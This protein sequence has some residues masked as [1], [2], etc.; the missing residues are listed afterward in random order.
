MMRWI[1]GSSLKLRLLVVALAAALM[2]FGVRQLQDASVDALPEFAPVTVEVQTEALGLSAVEV[3]ELITVPIEQNL[4]NGVA[5]LDEIQSESLVGLSRIVMR[6]E[7]GTDPLRARQVVQERLTQWRD[8]PRVSKPPVMIQPL[9]ATSRVMIVR[10]SSTELSPIDMSVLARWTIKP[11]LMG[12]PGVANVSIWGQRERQLQVLVDPARLRERG[13]TLDQVIETTGNALWVSPLSFLEASVPG[14][15]GFIDTPNQRLGIQ[16]VLAINTPEELAQVPIEGCTG[17]FPS[18]TRHVDGNCPAPPSARPLALLGDVAT[19]VEDHQPLIG[20][21][22]STGDPG[23]MLVIEKFPEMNTLAVTEEL[24]SALAD[25]QPGLP[26]LTMDT[27][28][29]RPATFIETALDNLATLLLLGGLLVLVLLGVFLFDWRTGLISA[30]AIPLSLV[31]AGFVLHLRGTTFNAIILAGFMVAI[32]AIVDDAI[33]DIDHIRRRLRQRRREG[34]QRST[35]S[36]ILEASLEVR[37]PIVYATLIMFLAAL[38]IFFYVDFEILGKMNSA[39]F[40]ELTTS[41]ALALLTSMVVALTVTPVLAGLL[42]SN[43]SIE[44]RE[45]PLVRSLGRRY[46]GLLARVTYRPTWAYAVVGIGLVAG[47]AL[48]PFVD[49][50]AGQSLLPAFKERDLLIHWQGAP[51]TSL[52]EMER[53]TTGVIRTPDVD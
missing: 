46:E 26:G 45:S 38:P 52:P 16:H 18:A 48:L 49:Q 6:F 20:D 11:R 22:V 47:L 53:I 5:F 50:A 13:V 40:W 41:Y 43:R 9:S 17:S 12:V 19:V 44:R 25:L 36:I 23:L 7:S 51:G 3:E 28:I 33:V 31:A 15:G 4:L 37:G 42:L 24:E 14:S 30:V 10:L 2:V 1:V 34:D 27:T 35:A 32:V 39:F 8:L 29:Y 21:D